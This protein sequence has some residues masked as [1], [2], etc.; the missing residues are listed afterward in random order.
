[1]IP[2]KLKILGFDYKVIEKETVLLDNEVCFGTHNFDYLTIE[3]GKDYPDQL[4][5]ATLLHEILHAICQIN[6][7]E[8]EETQIEVLANGL[9]AVLKENKM[10]Y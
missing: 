9:Y 4:K 7:I 5:Q 8:W 2:K 3:I 10:G 6:G 1:M